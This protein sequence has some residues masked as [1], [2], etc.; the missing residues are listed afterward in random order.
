[1][2]NELPLA[3]NP[4]VVHLKPLTSYAEGFEWFTKDTKRRQAGQA[5]VFVPEPVWMLYKANKDSFEWALTQTPPKELPCAAVDDDEE[6]WFYDSYYDPNLPSNLPAEEKMWV[7][8]VVENKIEK[9]N[10][11]TSMI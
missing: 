6:E 7:Y 9:L 1:M 10:L 8:D 2:P 3:L 11:K 5:P 4:L